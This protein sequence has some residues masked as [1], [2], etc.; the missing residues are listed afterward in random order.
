MQNCYIDP[1]ILQGAI[2][3]GS[4]CEK[5]GSENV[6]VDVCTAARVEK[7]IEAG[8]LGPAVLLTLVTCTEYCIPGSRPV[9]VV[10]G[11]LSWLVDPEEISTM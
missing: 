7:L 4:G 2:A 10:H 11:P 9:N 8:T 6:D 5:D 1:W 3:N